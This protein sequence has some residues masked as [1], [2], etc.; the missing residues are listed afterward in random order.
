MPGKAGDK[1]PGKGK[2]TTPKAPAKKRNRPS[3]ATGRKGTATPV[4]PPCAS[5]STAKPTPKD[6][7][8][9]RPRATDV[10]M[11]FRILE[12]K[13]MLLEGYH[14]PDIVQLVADKW[15]NETRQADN[16]IATARDEIKAE[17]ESG[18]LI[19]IE[20]HIASRVN[21]F[22]R[23]LRLDDNAT[24]LRVIDSLHKITPVDGGGTRITFEEDH[25]TLGMGEESPHQA[26]DRGEG[27][28]P[29]MENAQVETVETRPV[30]T[31]ETVET[32]RAPRL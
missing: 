11:T 1:K 19:N 9:G 27:K 4:P 32:T 10:E 29:D 12:V 30:E 28:P 23:S 5:E 13:K 25:E 6:E 18:G 17:V 2:G 26:E 20:W 14:R 8:E 31:K 16:Y 24:A 21:L 22:N 7:K 15:G 3:G